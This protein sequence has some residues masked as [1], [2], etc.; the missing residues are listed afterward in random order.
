MNLDKDL[1]SRQMVRDL[2]AKA[3][4]AQEI[5]STWEQPQIDK[6]VAAIAD[7]GFAHGEELAKMACTETGFGNV[8]DKT[9]KNQFASK[10]VYEA[11]KDMKTIGLLK[12]DA[13][14]RTWDI[15]VPVGVIAG[16]APSTNPTST[17]IYKSLIALKGGN[18]IVFSPHPG[19]SKS[20]LRAVEIIMDAAKKAGCPEGAISAISLPTMSAVQELMGH[21]DIRLILATGGAAMVRAAYTSGTPAIGVGAGNG[22]AYIHPSA[23]IQKAVSLI[24]SSKTFDNG[25]ICA[26]EQSIITERSTAEAVEQELKRQGGYF[27]LSAEIAKL[28]TFLFSPKGGIN[29]KAVGK[30]ALEIAKQAGIFSV[31]ANTKV[32]LVPQTEVG[33]AHPFSHEK[34]CP[35][36]AYYVAENTDDV[37]S[38]TTDILRY[39]GSGHTFSMH[40]QDTDVVRKFG[41]KMPVSRFLVNTGSTFGG[42]GYSTNLFP[43]LT[44]G[45][46]AVGGSSSS[47]N[48]GPLDLIN[49]RRVAWGVR[50]IAPPVGHTKIGAPADDVLIEQLMDRILKKLK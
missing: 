21:K 50:D 47:N 34:L 17:V 5:L 28:Q 12:E 23:N 38:K 1:Q 42:I 30:S 32:L 39:E 26:S 44:L 35:V 20:T 11:I 7:A 45:C 14:M 8:N 15:G 33:K 13:Q 27:L 41:R 46:G 43:A 2:V 24:I 16:I 49:I 18:T 6:V 36:L 25:T 10:N 9:I 48:I 29:V 40:T 31:P 37:L 19:A 4:E 3:L 22:P